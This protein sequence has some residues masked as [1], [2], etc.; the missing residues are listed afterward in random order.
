MGGA[1]LAVAALTALALTGRR[2]EPGLAPFEAAGVMAAIPVETIRAVDVRDHDRHWRFQRIGEG[3][4]HAG[5]AAAP[6]ADA[7]T[8]VTAALRFLHASA[9][10]RRLPGIEIASPQRAEFGLDPPRYVVSVQAEGQ[11]PFEVAFGAINPQGLAQYVQVATDP[12][13]LL[14]QRYVGEA[15]EAAMR[16]P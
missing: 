15:W 6:G 9:P 13:V 5:S 2:P 12:D 3:W 4:R 7:T 8:L 1:A 14:L 11:R 10:Q 16:L